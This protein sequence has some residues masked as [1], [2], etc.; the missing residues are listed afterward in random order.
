MPPKPDTPLADQLRADFWAQHRQEMQLLFMYKRAYRD[1]LLFKTTDANKTSPDYDSTAEQLKTAAITAQA[2]W[3]AQQAA[4]EHWKA[5]NPAVAPLVANAHEDAKAHQ[6]AEKQKAERAEFVSELQGKEE[7]HRQQEIVRYDNFTYLMTQAREREIW[8]GRVE[9]LTRAQAII[10][11]Q[12]RA[13]VKEEQRR[14]AAAAAEEERKK[15]EAE[16]EEQRKAD[17]AQAAEETRLMNELVAAMAAQTA[18][19]ERAKDEA[20]RAAEAQ[21]E[22]QRPADENLVYQA[23]GDPEEG[24]SG[25]PDHNMLKKDATKA[26]SG[27]DAK[28]KSVP[29]TMPVGAQQHLTEPSFGLDQ[30]MA[31]DPFVCSTASQQ[32][33]NN[34]QH[35]FN[36]GMPAMGQAP[37][38]VDTAASQ[39]VQLPA[40]SQTSSGVANRAVQQMVQMPVLAQ[41]STATASP[42]MRQQMAQIPTL[43]QT[44]SK[45]ASPMMQ[46]SA[47]VFADYTMFMTQPSQTPPPASLPAMRSPPSTHI[48]AHPSAT[49]SSDSKRK[50]RA[51]HGMDSPTKRRQSVNQQGAVVPIA[52]PP[53]VSTIPQSFQDPAQSNQ[54]PAQGVQTPAR[55]YQTPPQVPIDPALH[56][57]ISP[58]SGGGMVFGTSIKAGICTAIAHIVKEARKGTVFSQV[59]LDGPIS[60]F[61]SPE[62]GGRIKQATKLHLVAVNA[63]NPEDNREAFLRGA[64]RVLQA[65]LREVERHG[66][67]FEKPLL[68]GPLSGPE[69]MSA[70]RAMGAVYKTV[71]AEY[72]S[73]PR[74]DGGCARPASVQQTPTRAPA[75]H[76]RVSSQSTVAKGSASAGSPHLPGQTVAAGTPVVGSSPQ[77]SGRAASSSPMQPFPTLPTQSGYPSPSPM[78]GY[79]DA[80]NQHPTVSAMPATAQTSGPMNGVPEPTNYYP[81]PPHLPALDQVQPQKAKKT[82]A[83]RKSRARSKASSTTTANT[84]APNIDTTTSTPPPKPKPSTT[85]QC[86]PRLYYRFAD[87]AFYMQLQNADG[88]ETHH[89]MGRGTDAA[90]AALGRFVAAA[91]EMGIEECPE[92]FVFRLWEGVE[93][94]L[95]ALGGAVFEAASGSGSSSAVGAV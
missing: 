35:M 26:K 28:A 6:A 71:M 76:A 49:P 4:F 43:E 22:V 59:L 47:P 85:N 67:V 40:L 9:A 64:F 16:A 77:V 69:L 68:D 57:G 31:S 89:R 53:P 48:A 66:S 15:K 25:C 75:A 29:M 62:I 46:Q 56:Y 36:A 39:T 18:E 30:V 80:V 38:T 3:T 54:T 55:N 24:Q 52:Q 23:L 70:R 33:P 88:T 65:V 86:I 84:P 58:P 50:A 21:R 83:R 60:D 34:G 93:G 73:P 37:G 81:S 13:V 61:G 42:V 19:E 41:T 8:R 78:N 11:A 14:V 10:E 94:N 2:A 12:R 95:R 5:A 82:P 63:T 20:K 91:R 1:W 44:S 32:L 7:K 74:F 72:T 79:T 51:G 92:G 45:A 27:S 17:E 87:G 90:E